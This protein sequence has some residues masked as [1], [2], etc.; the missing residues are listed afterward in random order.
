MAP[1]ACQL[2]LQ[3]VEQDYLFNVIRTVETSKRL[4]TSVVSRKV[5]DTEAYKLSK[6][7]EISSVEF[8]E[9]EKQSGLWFA[10]DSVVL[11]LSQYH[12]PF[13]VTTSRYKPLR[14]SQPKMPPGRTG[15]VVGKVLNPPPVHV[16][17]L[18]EFLSSVR[19]DIVTENGTWG[20]VNFPPHTLMINLL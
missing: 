8:N 4:K 1:N 13:L 3:Y 12:N 18:Q 16:R 6:R 11:V 7:V 14:G 15:I 2:L 9:L 20:G 5:K 19:S 17:Q 10:P